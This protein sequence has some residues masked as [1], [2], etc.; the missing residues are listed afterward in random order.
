MEDNTDKQGGG[1]VTGYGT[2]SNNG[3]VGNN[4]RNNSSDRSTSFQNYRLKPVAVEVTATVTPPSYPL[5]SHP[6]PELELD[7]D[8]ESS[9]EDPQPTV[10]A[11]PVR[12][13]VPNRWNQAMNVSK[14]STP[15][16][17]KGSTTPSWMKPK[18]RVVMRDESGTPGQQNDSSRVDTPRS[19]YTR[20]P[21]N[22]ASAATPSNT[23]TPGSY[24]ARWQPPSRSPANNQPSST[25]SDCSADRS[26]PKTTGPSPV[27]R[28]SPWNTP[29]KSTPA[30]APIPPA[31]AAKPT[32][33]QVELRKTSYLFLF[34]RSFVRSFVRLF[35]LVSLLLSLSLSH[36]RFIR[37]TAIPAATPTAAA[38][39]KVGEGRIPERL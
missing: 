22:K 21:S 34:V 39:S 30:P 31:A 11:P 37:V 26:A 10:Q 12:Q 5:E 32:W 3:R 7:A 23:G 27:S 25:T 1:P 4:S 8:V 35:L 14:G 18:L 9:D 6:D 28:S 13:S 29:A 16:Q 24:T 36:F 38:A 15:S 2:R 20:T 17:V 19:T 33:M